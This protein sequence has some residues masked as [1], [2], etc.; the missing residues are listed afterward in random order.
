MGDNV[1]LIDNT[2]PE[3]NGLYKVRS[4]EYTGGFSGLRQVVELDYLI[5]I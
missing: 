4:V 1:Q 2:L 5:L 3:R